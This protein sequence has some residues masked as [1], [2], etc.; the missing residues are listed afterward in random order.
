MPKVMPHRSSAI[1][2]AALVT[3]LAV[4][5]PDRA[6]AS[7]YC[8]FHD[9]YTVLIARCA[10]MDWCRPTDPVYYSQPILIMKGKGSSAEA[11]KY[12]LMAEKAAGQ[13]AGA[14]SGDSTGGCYDNPDLIEADLLKPMRDKSPK[15][16]FVLM[17]F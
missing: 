11:E 2:A 16:K 14:Y 12:R 3:G 1:V 8:P 13:R 15:D 9:G 17:R 7:A 6:E 5:M 4:S 10:V